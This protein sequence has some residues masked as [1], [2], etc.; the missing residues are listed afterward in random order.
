MRKNREQGLKLNPSKASKTETQCTAMASW[1]QVFRFSCVNH[2]LKDVEA[3]CHHWCSE[4]RSSSFDQESF[5]FIQSIFP[6]SLL[7]WVPQ[8]KTV[9]C[10]PKMQSPVAPQRPNPPT[11]KRPKLPKRYVL[12]ALHTLKAGFVTLWFG[13]DHSKEKNSVIYAIFRHASF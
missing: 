1:L 10:L 7:Q 9:L 3:A 4:A 13:R 12:R 8:F 5:L 2:V 6:F 11:R